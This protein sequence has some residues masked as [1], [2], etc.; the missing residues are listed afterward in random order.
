MIGKEW[1]KKTLTTLQAVKRTQQILPNEAQHSR[2]G[3]KSAVDDQAKVG[4]GSYVKFKFR[5]M[6]LRKT[7][8]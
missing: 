8:L 5:P 6:D 1:V 7:V 2:R 3:L 4:T